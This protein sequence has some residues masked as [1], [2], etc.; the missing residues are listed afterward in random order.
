MNTENQLK[1]GRKDKRGPKQ[2]QQSKNKLDEHCQN[3]RKNSH[4]KADCWSKAGGGGQGLKAKPKLKKD[5]KIEESVVVAVAGD[6]ES[7]A[8]I[9]TTDQQILLPY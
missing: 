8:F 5:F 1:H 4:S 3:C 2:R 9:C 7:F 6:D